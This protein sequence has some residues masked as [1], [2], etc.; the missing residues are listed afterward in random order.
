MVVT[1]IGGRATR[2]II[3]ALPE[4]GQCDFACFL[5]KERKL[6]SITTMGGS[7]V[8]LALAPRQA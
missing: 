2:E 3:A 7:P 8:G 5:L 4:I 6:A 1:I